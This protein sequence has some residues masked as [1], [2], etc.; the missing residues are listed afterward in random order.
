MNASPIMP[1]R[2]AF[3]GVPKVYLPKIN[4]KLNSTVPLKRQGSYTSNARII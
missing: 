2:L 3:Q 1:L 4:R